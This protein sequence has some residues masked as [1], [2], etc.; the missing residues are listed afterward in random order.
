MSTNSD[1]R[2]ERAVLYRLFASLFIREPDDE[3]LSLV[4]GMFQMKSFEQPDTIGQDFAHIFLGPWKHFPPY[5][6]FY[7]LDPEEVSGSKKKIVESVQSFYASAG[8]FLDI[9]TTM[10]P[11]HLSAELVFM[12]YLAEN[13]LVEHQKRFL[14]SHLVKWVPRYCDAVSI[15]ANTIFYKEV[16][17]LL[18]EFILSES[19]QLGLQR[20]HIEG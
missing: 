1:E 20:G 8:L 18:K 17:N 2:T 10:L 14:E 3:I 4:R 19:E 12:S 16:A 9:N 13:S 7:Y 6:S 15:H 5:E 11:D